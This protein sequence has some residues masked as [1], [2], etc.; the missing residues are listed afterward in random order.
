MGLFFLEIVSNQLCRV[1][2]IHK[3]PSEFHP[4]KNGEFNPVK[5][6]IV[7]ICTELHF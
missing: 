7:P 3:I 4:L 1:T 5:K 2:V 6:R